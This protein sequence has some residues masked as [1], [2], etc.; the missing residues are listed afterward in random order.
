MTQALNLDFCPIDG[1]VDGVLQLADVRQ[2]G[3]RYGRAR[4][5]VGLPVERFTG[6]IT[7][8]FARIFKFSGLAAIC[9]SCRE[10]E[11]DD[12]SETDHVKKPS[13][14]SKAEMFNDFNLQ[15]SSKVDQFV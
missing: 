14:Y 12:S 13:K 6:W 11:R 7:R 10:I 4:T 3:V 15:S 1:E 2:R 5:V 9:Q 8:E